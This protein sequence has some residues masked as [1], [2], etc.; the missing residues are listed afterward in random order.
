MQSTEKITDLAAMQK[1]ID[2]M[3]AEQQATQNRINELREVFKGCVNT[4]DN[5][6]VSN[7]LAKLNERLTLLRL[8]V[9]GLREDM[10]GIIKASKTPSNHLEAR[11][12][13]VGKP[14][15]I[16]GISLD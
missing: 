9:K 6:E 15:Q 13:I 5:V 2:D 4:Y 11:I 14:K 12:Q 10:A 7:E 1:S 3:V 8:Y 16:R